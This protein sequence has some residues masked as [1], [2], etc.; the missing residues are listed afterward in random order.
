MATRITGKM[1]G[2]RTGNDAR[3][4][5]VSCILAKAGPYGRRRGRNQVMLRAR[6]YRYA[7]FL[8]GGAIALGVTMLAA[9]S[10]LAI[11]GRSEFAEI[12]SALAE[13][14]GGLVFVR[15]PADCAATASPVDRAALRLLD[16]GV[17]VHGA[18]VRASGAAEAVRVANRRFPHRLVSRGAT[19]SLA[20]VGYKSTPI[21]VVVTADGD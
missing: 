5:T 18:V 10:V 20:H 12:R 6:I 9:A 3:S 2:R 19:S 14:G 1:R 7:G 16:Q 13:Q 4:D 8:G 15:N 17:V 21:A 11:G